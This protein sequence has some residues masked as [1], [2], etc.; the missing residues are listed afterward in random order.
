ML[1]ENARCAL[2][3]RDC[4][5]KNGGMKTKTYLAVAA[6][7]SALVKETAPAILKA[8]P[9]AFVVAGSVSNYWQPSFEWTE[10]CFR[11]GVL[12][13]GIRGWS[14]HPYGVKTPEEH[15]WGHD[16]TL[17][18]MKK[19]GKVLPLLDTERGFTA[20]KRNDIT[21]EGWAG[22]DEAMAGDYQAWHIVREFL[23]DQASGLALTS[24]YELKGNE[25]F[26]LYE[27]DGSHRPAMKAYLAFVAELT[28][29]RFAERR[30]SLTATR[31]TARAASAR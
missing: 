18:L 6:E 29:Y 27:K 3:A 5:C 28:G 10:E 4:F 11:N 1:A 9:K 21:I 16:V 17:G 26:T 24:W 12:E 2:A 13:S 31:A 7:Y 20:Q 30:G 15:K 25:G 22:G 14:V 8:D 23:A 19:Y